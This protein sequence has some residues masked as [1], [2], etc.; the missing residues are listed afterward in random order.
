[1]GE[2][3]YDSE[4]FMEYPSL[5]ATNLFSNASGDVNGTDESHCSFP[6]PED[7]LRQRDE[8]MHSFQINNNIDLIIESN[9][10]DLFRASNS[11]SAIFH[12]DA[13]KQDRWLDD[14]TGYNSEIVVDSLKISDAPEADFI[15]VTNSDGPVANKDR[16]AEWLWTLH[17]IGMLMFSSSHHTITMACSNDQNVLCSGRCGQN[18]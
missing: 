16:V 9:P 17:R 3:R 6:V 10:S 1:M 7:R 12:S 8:R 15:D 13:F 4:T 11:D 2:P 18:R 14:T 5:P